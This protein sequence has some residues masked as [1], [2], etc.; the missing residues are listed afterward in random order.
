MHILFICPT[1]ARFD[2]AT[3][4]SEGL[5]GIESTNIEL[6]RALVRRGHAVTLLTH[7]ERAVEADGVVNRPLKELRN[8]RA[9]V[10]VSSNDP[11]LLEG[12]AGDPRTVLW[13]HNP[14]PVEKALRRGYVLPI[15]RLAPDAVFVGEVAERAAS[16]LYRFRSRM[17][18]PH[19]L[20]EAFRTAPVSDG[21]SPVFVFASQ[22]QRGLDRTLRAWHESGVYRA[23]GG[24]LRVYG[25]AQE[26]LRPAAARALRLGVSFHSRLTAEQLAQAYRGCRA[27]LYPGAVDETFCLAAA[28]AQAMGLPVVTLG[29]GALAER[30]RH[31]IDGLVARDDREFAHFAALL[32]RDDDLWR[33]LHEGALLQRAALTWDRAAVLW[34][35]LLLNQRDAQAPL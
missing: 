20:G 27:M 18:I 9:D 30:V 2:L 4:A 16:R 34:A 13:M 22:Q 7:T 31:G 26:D 14:L 5:G 32:A 21:G 33:H 19:G 8:I 3:P 15:L 25:T 28:E 12:L 6:C 10:A 17:V 1:R 11:R 29:I 35:S 23:L 24:S